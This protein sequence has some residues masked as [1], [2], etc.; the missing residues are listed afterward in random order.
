MTEQIKAPMITKEQIRA[1]RDSR[2]QECGEK[3]AA[4]LDEYDCI[5]I[6]PIQ[7]IDGRLVTPQIQV[8]AK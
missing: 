4:L 8:V 2:A 7:V 3:I 5:L 6:A 1:D